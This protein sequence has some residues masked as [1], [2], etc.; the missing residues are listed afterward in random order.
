[1]AKREQYYTL[2]L[3]LVPHEPG[4][5]TRAIKHKNYKIN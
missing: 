5:V 2:G 3:N 1:M 4:L